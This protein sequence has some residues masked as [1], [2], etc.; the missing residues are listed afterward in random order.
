LRWASPFCPPWNQAYTTT[1]RLGG[2]PL[3]GNSVSISARAPHRAPTN[4]R[5]FSSSQHRRFM[6]DTDSTIYALSTAPGRAAIAV[7][8]ISGPACASVRF[9]RRTPQSFPHTDNALPPSRYTKPYAQT[10]PSQNHVSRRYAPSTTPR[11][12]PP[13]APS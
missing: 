5:S 9:S 7:V 6:L 10:K 12:R 8:R 13:Q 11:I 4:I 3:F 1:A 2:R